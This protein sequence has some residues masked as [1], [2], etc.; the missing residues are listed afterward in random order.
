M[1][2][3]LPDGG[4]QETACG[5]AGR[6]SAGSGVEPRACPS[7]TTMQ[8]PGAAVMRTR[9]IPRTGFVALED[10]TGSESTGTT[11]G[12]GI[13]NDVAGGLEAIAVGIGGVA[14]KV[15]GG[16]MRRA[17]KKTTAMAATDRSAPSVTKSRAGGG[18]INVVA[19][20]SCWRSWGHD[21]LN[22]AGGLAPGGTDGG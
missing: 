17:T 20:R 5:P 9:H 16:A 11:G 4:L 18:W 21:E 15:C 6:L 19:L 14:L 8:E 10:A 2:F 7:M 22:A 3:T 12:S 13:S 1:V